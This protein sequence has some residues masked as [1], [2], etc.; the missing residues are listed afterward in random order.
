V[1]RYWYRGDR[2]DRG[3]SACLTIGSLRV[4]RAVV[5]SILAVIEACGN[6]EQGRLTRLTSALGNCLT[7]IST[8]LQAR[9]FAKILLDIPRPNLNKLLPLSSD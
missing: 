5:R 9:R 1:P 2:G 8:F 4:D 3:S 7:A 6:D